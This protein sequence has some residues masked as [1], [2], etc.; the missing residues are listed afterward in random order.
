MNI[1]TLKAFL[2]VF[3]FF[4]ETLGKSTLRKLEKDWE[5]HA[6]RGKFDPNT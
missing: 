3:L 2:N 5:H 6:A 1:A 4:S